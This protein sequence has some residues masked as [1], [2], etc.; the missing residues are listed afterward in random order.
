MLGPPEGLG[1]RNMRMEPGS[2]N[3][4]QS[5]CGLS[6]RVIGPKGLTDLQFIVRL[7]LRLP[8]SQRQVKEQL[9]EVRQQLVKKLAPREFP[10]GVDLTI[11]RELPANGRDIDWLRKE[12]SN[13]DKLNRGDVEKGRVSGAV[14]HVRIEISAGDVADAIRVAKIST[15]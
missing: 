12:W 11:C 5:P 2:M 4:P 1:V 15:P 14:Y 6:T 10:E 3:V 8:S 13:M 9:G 7:A